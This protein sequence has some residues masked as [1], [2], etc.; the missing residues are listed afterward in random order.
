[1]KIPLQSMGPKIEEKSSGNGLWT[2]ADKLTSV[3]YV[4]KALHWALY[5]V[6]FQNK[7]ELYNPWI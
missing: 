7:S 5:H 1:M 6:L 4:R 2:N 3:I